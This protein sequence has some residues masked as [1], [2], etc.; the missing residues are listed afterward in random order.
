MTT[1]PPPR[2]PAAGAWHG[3]YTWAF[4]PDRVHPTSFTLSLAGSTLEGA[5][6]DEGGEF[7]LAGT[8][9]G[10][11][12][13]ARW[14]KRYADHGAAPIAY[15]GRLSPE[16]ELAGRWRIVDGAETGRFALR[17]GDGGMFETSTRNA[18]AA[19]RARTRAWQAHCKVDLEALRFDG[20]RAVLAHLLG[21]PAYVH[22][23]QR[24]TAERDELVGAMR[25]RAVA[26]DRVRLRRAMVPGVFKLLD[27]CVEVLGLT[28]PVELYVVN[29]GAMNA[30]VITSRDHGISVELTQGIL[31]ALEPAE[32]LSV[33][34]HELGHALLGHLETP[35]VLEGDSVSGLTCLRSFALQRYEEVSADRVGLLCCDD[36]AVALRTEFILTTGVTNRALLGDPAA[37][38]EH[39]R[40]ALA[41]LEKTGAEA[42]NPYGLD[43]HPYGEMRAVAVDLFA[44]STTFAKLM[45][46]AGGELDEARMERDVARL[47]RLMNPS[48]V[49]AGLKDTD[50]L[51]LLLL[52]AIAVAEATRGTSAAEAKVIR[53]L[54]REHPELDERLREMTFEEQQ[55]RLVELAEL[56]TATLP[57][58]ARAGVVDDLT[59]VA[60]ADGRI[61][62]KERRVLDAIAGLLGLGAEGVG[63]ALD[64]ANAGLD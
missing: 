46:R 40:A 7:T 23:M 50:T 26:Y 51:E 22:A 63:D 41:A 28:A 8:W 4:D 13:V 60:Q 48:A 58:G 1:H 29:D 62:A 6:V 11:R 9:D 37:F 36:L 32:L 14:Q 3:H 47:V 20:E 64:L 55:V 34:G 21:D 33:L 31:N 24:A 59:L 18:K 16:G 57:V 49:E 5:G 45:G 19:L 27:R 52:G 44:R 39:A 10:T 38:L 43:T 17:P 61:S 54:G 53:R 42:L 2:A 56:L 35:Q 12:A 25:R 30:H 15:V